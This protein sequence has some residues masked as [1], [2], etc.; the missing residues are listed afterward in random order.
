[1]QNLHV[2][3]NSASNHTKPRFWNRSPGLGERK[4]I[5]VFLDIIHR[6]IFYLEHNVS[7]TGL[8]PSA[9][10]NLRKMETESSLR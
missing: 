3:Y 9:G 4:A 8:S 10:K 2:Q 1:M 5:T 6:P 7:E